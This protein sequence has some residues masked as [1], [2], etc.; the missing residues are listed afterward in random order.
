M[1]I[2][3]LNLSWNSLCMR[4]VAAL[5]AGLKVTKIIHSSTN[6]Q[7]RVYSLQSVSNCSGLSLSS[8]KLDSEAAPSVVEPFGPHRGRVAGSGPETKQQTEAAGSQQ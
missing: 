8:V 2:E 6:L 5:S 4:G 3:V 1:G 7:C